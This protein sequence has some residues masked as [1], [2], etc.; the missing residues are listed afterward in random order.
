MSSKK[1]GRPRIALFATGGT[2]ASSAGSQAQLRDYSVTNKIE[3]ML[4]AV[5]LV[6]DLADIEPEQVC[7]VE[8]HKIGDEILLSLA[9]KVRNACDR[10]EIDG[11]VIT[12]GTD[13]LEETAYFLH[14]AIPTDKPIVLV[15]AMRPA[16]ALSADG[17][18]NL[19]Q[20]VSVASHPASCAQGVLVVM[21]DRILSA[22]H[23]TK[24]H[25]SAV[26]AFNAAEFG[27]L[28]LVS[29]DEVRFQNRLALRHTST[30]EVVLS[31]D[32]RRLPEVD[33]IYDH[34]GAGVHHFQASID[35]GV[36]GIVLA[37]TGQGSL[38][39]QALDGVIRAR[40]AGVMVVRSS[41]VWQGAVAPVH[42]DTSLGLVA[43]QTLNPP[44]ARILLRLALAKAA[45][46]LGLQRIFDTH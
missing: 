16:T 31:E 12:H 7:N 3:E 38:S 24:T 46:L 25:T 14:L 32:V 36:S 37:A 45:D 18:L 40:A 5:P 44:K 33:V 6:G 35:S 30:S 4:A 11:V 1:S 26:D 10:P 39:P 13:T 23:V 41:R 15:G 29:G 17:S 9:A 8:S 27:C 22:R 2:I 43:G 42:K 20:A 19:L 21:N 28:G 34:Q